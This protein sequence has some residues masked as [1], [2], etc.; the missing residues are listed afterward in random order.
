M[1]FE[2]STSRK[3]VYVL[4]K[5]PLNDTISSYMSHVFFLHVFS[6]ISHNH[7]I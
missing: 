4:I 6:L 1:L 7:L 2:V 5:Y 3:T